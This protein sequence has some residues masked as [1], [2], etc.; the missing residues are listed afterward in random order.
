MTSPVQRRHPAI[1]DSHC[2]L[3]Y[4]TLFASANFGPYIMDDRESFKTGAPTFSIFIMAQTKCAQHQLS[5]RWNIYHQKYIFGSNFHSKPSAGMAL[6][7]L[8]PSYVNVKVMDV[9][10]V[11]RMNRWLLDGQ[12]FITWR[13]ETGSRDAAI[14]YKWRWKHANKAGTRPPNGQHLYSD[15][16]LTFFLLDTSPCIISRPGETV[17]WSDPTDGQFQAS[18]DLK[19]WVE[20]ALFTWGYKC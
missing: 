4:F 10:R 9:W 7:I 19:M 15:S 5:R 2:F 8:A 13:R 14:C 18:R 3:L 20:A 1:T 12:H 17:D 6:D 16:T 11:L